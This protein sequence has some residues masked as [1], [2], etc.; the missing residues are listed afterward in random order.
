M[1]WVV[2]P[3]RK[4]AGAWFPGRFTPGKDPVPILEEAGWAQR[5]V[6]T[7]GEN[8][9]PQP[10]FDLQTVQPV[11]EL[12]VHADILNTSVCIGAQNPPRAHVCFF[13]FCSNIHWVAVST[14]SYSWGTQAV[15]TSLVFGQH[16]A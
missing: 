5:P 10:G 6:W 12:L 9:A 2:F 15:G 14:G 3:G 7:G 1:G 13:M 16:T 4:A 11:V 8:L